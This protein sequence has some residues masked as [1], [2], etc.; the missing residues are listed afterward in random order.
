MYDAQIAEAVEAKLV[1]LDTIPV[2]SL[3]GRRLE[4]DNKLGAEATRDLMRRSMVDIAQRV[5]LHFFQLTP[6]VALE[7]VIIVS[8]ARNHDTAGLIKSLINSFMIA[9]CT[10]ETSERAYNQLLE[11]EALRKEVAVRR[12]LRQT[13]ASPVKH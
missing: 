10:P 12:Q 2:G 6:P 9:Y 8:A 3:S 1:E 11:L 4:L 5:G 13:P 7:Q